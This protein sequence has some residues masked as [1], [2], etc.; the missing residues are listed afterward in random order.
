MESFA[1][2]WRSMLPSPEA[3]SSKSK[4]AKSSPKKNFVLLRCNDG[5]GMFFIFQQVLAFCKSYEEGAFY[6]VEVDFE[7]RGLYYDENY[8]DNWWTYYFSPICIGERKNEKIFFHHQSIL[9]LIEYD[10]TIEELN[11]LILKYVHVRSEIMEEVDDFVAQMFQRNFVICV[12]YRGT[13]KSIEAPRVGYDTVQKKVVDVIREHD[14]ESIKI[15]I[16]TDEENFLQFMQRQFGNLVCYNEHAVRSVN[17]TPIH[18][19]AASPYQSG[20]D[21]LVDCLL[22][23]RG[24]Y[25]IRTSSNLSLASTFFNPEIPVFELSKRH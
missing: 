21:A 14:G 22:L 13:D 5:G 1:E 6:G 17:N 9:Q 16:A 11:S 19:N 4:K 7:K 12:H 18:F 10:T 25:L 3:K 20:R 23:S 24:S 15:F 2:E 8:G